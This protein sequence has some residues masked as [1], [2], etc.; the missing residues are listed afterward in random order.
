MKTKEKFYKKLVAKYRSYKSKP[1]AKNVR[2]AIANCPNKIPVIIISYNNGVYVQNTVTQLMKYNI[3][4]IIIDNCSRDKKTLKVLTKVQLNNEAIV[5]F[6]KKNFGHMVGFLDS[7]YKILP[8]I[9]AY[10]DPDL[11]FNK[12]LP[13]DFLKIMSN[14]A[15]QYSVYKVGFALELPENEE[16]INTEH[17]FKRTKPFSWSKVTPIKNIEQQ[18]WQK[19]LSNKDLDLYASPVDTTFAVYNKNNFN[20][21]FYDGIR[22]GGAYSAIHLPWFPNL[23]LM[24][25]QERTEYLKN[26]ISTTSVK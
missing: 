20:G 23:D 3:K 13:V 16:F 10:T 21:D 5:V 19:K 9:F 4:P 24:N 15:S 8:N 12:N 14:V 1:L 25:Q 7:V 17:T 18:Y 6:S 22:I 11:E 2:E 26:N